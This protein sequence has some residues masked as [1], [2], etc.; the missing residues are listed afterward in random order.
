MHFRVNT[1]QEVCENFTLPELFRQWNLLTQANKNHLHHS[2]KEGRPGRF[3]LSIYIGVVNGFQLWHWLL[4]PKS[5][6][7]GGRNGSTPI[8]SFPGTHFLGNNGVG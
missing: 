6:Y 7:A 3:V 4:R 1:Y 2:G 8:V 5:M